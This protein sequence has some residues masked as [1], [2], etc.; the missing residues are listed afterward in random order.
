MTEKANMDPVMFDFGGRFKKLTHAA[1]EAIFRRNLLR[2]GDDWL[3]AIP[4]IRHSTT[5]QRH[6]LAQWHHIDVRQE[7]L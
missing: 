6:P 1:T 3:P 4:S 2:E 7:I 5:Q